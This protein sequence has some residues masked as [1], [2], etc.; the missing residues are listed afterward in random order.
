MREKQI[1]RGSV[2]K[3]QSI[4]LDLCYSPIVNAMLRTITYQ[5]QMASRVYQVWLANVNALMS[6]TQLK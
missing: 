4:A 1:I 6:L 2:V 5:R 3:G